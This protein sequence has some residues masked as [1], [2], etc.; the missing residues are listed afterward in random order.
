MDCFKV[1]VDCFKIDV[2]LTDDIYDNI[3]GRLN[4]FVADLTKCMANYNCQPNLVFYLSDED[5]GEAEG[6]AEEIS[7]VI[8]TRNEEAMIICD[9]EDDESDCLDLK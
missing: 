4:E 3:K 8:N 2:A 5:E 1:N 7:P 6:K 9:S